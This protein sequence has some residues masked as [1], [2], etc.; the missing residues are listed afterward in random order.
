M[1]K[2]IFLNDKQWAERAEHHAQLCRQI[3]ELEARK[4]E[5]AAEF[6]RGLKELEEEEAR[7]RQVVLS[8]QEEEE[9]VQ[10]ELPLPD[11]PA[12]PITPADFEPKDD[13]ERDVDAALAEPS[14][15]SPAGQEAVRRFALALIAQVEGHP[16][17]KAEAFAALEDLQ[18]AQGLLPAPQLPPMTEEQAARWRAAGDAAGIDLYPFVCGPCGKGFKTLAEAEAHKP[19]CTGQDIGWTPTPKET[20]PEI[21][22]VDKVKEL[23]DRRNTL[24]L[25]EHRPVNDPEVEELDTEIAKLQEEIDQA[26]EAKERP[27]PSSHMDEPA[28]CSTCTA[29]LP[30]RALFLV[31]EAP[32]CADCLNATHRLCTR[33]QVWIR[34][35]GWEGHQS[36]V[37]AEAP[38][39]P[40]KNKRGKKAKSAATA[41]E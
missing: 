26:F 17:A 18:R 9:F 20:P 7:L 21:P 4:K 29:K 30:R 3:A 16:E 33:C 31:G 41:A 37:H 24:V 5:A 2:L 39:G 14:K 11:P 23:L 15:L 12:K 19:E 34:F 22:Q 36:E 40:K 13:F 1:G 32:Q 25:E 28:P 35:E 8:H 27:K 10:Q 38:A 6:S